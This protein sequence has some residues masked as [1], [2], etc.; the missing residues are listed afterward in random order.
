MCRVRIFVLQSKEGVI[1]NKFFIEHR[2]FSG[3]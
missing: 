2:E 3:T 1:K